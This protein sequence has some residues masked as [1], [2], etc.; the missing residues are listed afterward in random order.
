MQAGDGELAVAQQHGA[1]LEQRLELAFALVE[2]H[3]LVQRA[4]HVSRVAGVLDRMVVDVE[5]DDGLVVGGARV[6]GSG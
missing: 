2:L 4:E 3:Y 6:L 1:V 5:W